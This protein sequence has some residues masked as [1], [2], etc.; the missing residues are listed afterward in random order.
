VRTNENIT[1]D[2]LPIEIIDGWEVSQ[3]N[4]IRY[5]G[6]KGLDNCVICKHEEF[7]ILVDESDKSPAARLDLPVRGSGY[8]PFAGI[9]CTNCGF[10][11]QFYWPLI[12]KWL[13]D[14]SEKNDG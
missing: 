14:E 6:A 10:L 1:D 12:I 11:Y 3:A 8:F 7:D 13:S 2:R 5:L 4:F 9:V